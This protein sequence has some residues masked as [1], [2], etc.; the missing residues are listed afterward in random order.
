[1]IAGEKTDNRVG[2]ALH[3]LNQRDDDSNRR[4]A[5]HG[6]RNDERVVRVREFASV[7]LFMGIGNHERL[8]IARKQRVKTSTRLP[9]QTVR[10]DKRAKLLRPVISR[11]PH[12]QLSQPG[13]V[14]A[15]QHHSP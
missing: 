14:A 2:I 8:P 9:Q 6:L 15:G 5:V 10:A 12:S 3:N 7:V 1:M 11:D 4:T 13:P